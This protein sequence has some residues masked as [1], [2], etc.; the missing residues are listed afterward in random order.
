M[1]RL[2][3][4]S[5]C[6]VVLAAFLGCDDAKGPG[7]DGGVNVMRAGDG[8]D[9]P[10]T[11]GPSMISP[12]GGPLACATRACSGAVADLCCPAACGASTDMDCA[13]CGNQRIEPGETCD[14]PGTCPT[15]CPQM[16]CQRRTL[17]NA[18]T[19]AATCVN[20]GLQTACISGDECCP[21]GCNAA[22]DRDCTASCGNGVVE[23]GESC[24]PVSGCV[25]S[26]PMVGCTMRRL[27]DAG[28]CIARCVEAG[29]PD[30]MS[31]RGRLLPAGMH[32][33]ERQT[34]AARAATGRGSR[35]RRVIRCPPARRPARRRAAGCGC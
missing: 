26:C 3:L 29:H 32:G 9:G 13:G 24:D 19:C 10:V 11:D 23:A 22:N 7:G 18:G 8:P 2:S 12:D 21:P 16:K 5:L 20:A 30:A 27:Q 33:R 14:P 34:T 15:S 4:R 35:T 17:T 6:L 1:N 25:Q 31:P 28:T